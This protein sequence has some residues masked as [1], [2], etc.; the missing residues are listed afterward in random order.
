[1]K[2]LH[3]SGARGW[4]GNEQQLILNINELNIL[5]T[6]NFIFGINNSDLHK[7]A[8]EN[9]INFI[10]SK[11]K[12]LSKLSNI[13]QLKNILKEKDIDVIHLHTSDSLTLFYLFSLFNKV[14]QKVI[15]SKKG[16]G[17]SSSFLSK[18]KYN[19]SK[20]NHIICVSEA[21][22]TDFSKILSPKNKSK[23][24]VVYD[25]ISTKDIDVDAN[26]ISEFTNKYD[27][28]PTDF[29]IGSIANHTKA[30]DIPTL[31]S[32]INILVTKYNVSNFKLVQVGE[33][34][35]LTPEFQAQIAALNLSNHIILTNKI[36]NAKMLNIIFDVFVVSSSREGGPS[37]AL[38]SMLMQTLIVTT[39]VGIM[40]EIIKNNVNGFICEA[41]DPNQ[42]A[43]SLFDAYTSEK[44]NLQSISLHNYEL[45]KAN[46]NSNKIANQLLNFYK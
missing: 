13:S 33:F 16:I 44:I 25:C 2:V 21:V 40:P 3:I 34:S 39:N 31:I 26:F 32:A 4:G 11:A 42:L 46:F 29:I 27:I 14:T 18:L 10:S 5:G 43:K 8:S 36:S 1:M 9:E 28:K 35:K 22:K 6:Q 37:S 45:V 7:A 12:K 20:I 24:A 17:S 38:E 41:G 23:L 15:F 30:K 19:S